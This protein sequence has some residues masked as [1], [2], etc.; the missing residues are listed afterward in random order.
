VRGNAPKGEIRREAQRRYRAR[1]RRGV[2]AITIDV[3]PELIDLLCR[4]RWLN[5][6]T[7]EHSRAEIRDALARLLADTARRS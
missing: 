7:V 5:E 4:L 1:I 3:G 6:S 2:M